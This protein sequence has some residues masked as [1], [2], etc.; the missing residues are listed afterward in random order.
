[1][2]ITLTENQYICLL[3][4]FAR[5]R[6]LL[7]YYYTFEK[8]CKSY[9]ERWIKYLMQFILNIERL[10]VAVCKKNIKKKQPFA[11]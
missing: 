11:T 3:K 10:N 6:Y 7:I 8:Y 2:L 1:M 9:N 4:V 5:R